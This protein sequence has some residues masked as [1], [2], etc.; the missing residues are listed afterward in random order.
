ML[1]L[2]ITV[3][4]IQLLLLSYNYSYS[5]IVIAIVERIKRC[6]AGLKARCSHVYGQRR[7][8][9]CSV[10]KKKI[11]LKNGKYVC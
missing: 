3:T 9:M 1:L 11:L 2:W 6:S 10:E 4:A 7:R 5:V 8:G